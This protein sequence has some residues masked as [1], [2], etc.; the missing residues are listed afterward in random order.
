MVGILITGHGHFATGIGSSLQLITGIAE[1]IAMVDFEE[2]HS[3]DTLKANLN[4]AIDSLSHC[5][6]ILVL[7]DLA[8][9]S[10]FHNISICKVERSD[11][12]IEVLA[13]TN[14]PMV[15]EGASMMAAY[16]DPADMVEA[17]I[18]TG[19]DYIIRFEGVKQEDRTKGDG[20]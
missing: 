13:G 2:D 8:G 11:Q 16:D 7:S 19:K 20:I 5:D 12:K 17:L 14:L 10:P 18:D 4:A 6:G 3:T 15:I 9:G 1:N